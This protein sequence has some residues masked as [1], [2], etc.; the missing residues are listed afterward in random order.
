MD[1]T[2][3]SK[4]MPEALLSVYVTIEYV[5]DGSRFVDTMWHSDITDKWYKE[6]ENGMT[7]DG[8]GNGG[9]RVVAWMDRPEPYRGAA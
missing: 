8:N 2:P 3:C 6:D 1:W 5:D 4:K 9:F 7:I